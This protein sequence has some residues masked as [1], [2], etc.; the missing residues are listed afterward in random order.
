M[1]RA[2]KAIGRTTL[3]ALQTLFGVLSS[4]GSG[5]ATP[6]GTSPATDTKK[7]DEYRP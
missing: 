1:L 4:L 6:P 3:L 2:L 5:G 7:R